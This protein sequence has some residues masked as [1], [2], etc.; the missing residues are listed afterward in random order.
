MKHFSILI[1]ALTALSINAQPVNDIVT[2]GP[3]YATQVWYDMA[4]GE[5]GSAPLNNWDIAFEIPGMTAAIRIN[6][7][8]GVRL[9]QAPFVVSEWADVD[10]AG[11]AENWSLLH[12][13]PANW[14][15][16]A[17][18]T[19]TDNEFDLGWGIYN[20][21]THV[22]SGDSIYVI[23]LADDTYKKLIIDHL[24]SGTYQFTF[25][26]I[27]GSNETTRQIAKSNF[28][29][30][31]FAYYDME[32]DQIRDREPFKTEW[33]LTFTKYV[34]FIGD[35]LMPYGV[36]GILHN[37]AATVAEASGVA[38]EEADP[39]GFEY[40]SDINTIGYDWKSFDFEQGYVLAEDLSFFV[41]TP[42]G[43]IYQL[44]MTGFEGASTGV[45]EFTVELASPA[46]LADAARDR[47]ELYPNP[48]NGQRVTFNWNAPDFDRVEV[49]SNTGA[50]VL[51]RELTD[52]GGRFEMDLASLQNGLY[53]VRLS[54][55]AGV[56][57]RKLVVTR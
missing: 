27:D 22:V 13:D 15:R 19:L 50:L 1:A 29:D 45:Y 31:Y 14:S 46:G 3:G 9:Y 53:V 12:D 26:D 25:A 36:T 34:E 7:Q 41:A 38:P 48:A 33:D 20:F 51:S 32:N 56:A 40:S 21:I 39:F 55:N 47:F 4:N 35:G 2:T 43:D 44:V 18:N 23:A 16:G 5:A 8:K 10:T 49:Y 28:V 30:K 37:P 57:S 11:M 54:G 24:A 6:E 52:A 42:E 17:F